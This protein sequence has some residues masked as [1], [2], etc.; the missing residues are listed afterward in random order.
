METNIKLTASFDPE[1][2]KAKIFC[3]KTEYV[4]DCKDEVQ[5][6]NIKQV[7]KHVASC[8]RNIGYNQAVESLQSRYNKPSTRCSKSKDDRSVILEGLGFYLFDDI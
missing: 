5:Y 3:Y 7:I 2:K 6:Q 4:L 8:M 1:L